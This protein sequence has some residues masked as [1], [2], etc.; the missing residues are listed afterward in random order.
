MFTDI[1]VAD[2]LKAIALYLELA[3]P[4]GCERQPPA[5]FASLDVATTIADLVNLPGVE[6]VS[7]SLVGGKARSVGYSFR[8][9]S[10]FYPYTK[11]VVRTTDDPP[12]YLLAIDAHDSIPAKLLSAERAELHRTLKE[13]NRDLSRSIMQAWED[14]GLPTQRSIIFSA[15]NQ[16]EPAPVGELS[17]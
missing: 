13:R 6:E 10:G 3:Y 1:P 5:C 16:K 11:L 14:A 4:P 8:L 15:F 12:G 2:L 9:G 7:G 17:Y